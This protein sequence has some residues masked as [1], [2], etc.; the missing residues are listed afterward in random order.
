MIWSFKNSGIHFDFCISKS[1][2]LKIFGKKDF[3]KNILQKIM[4]IFLLTCYLCIMRHIWLRINEIENS[5]LFRI[6]YLKQFNS[7]VNNFS[8]NKGQIMDEFNFQELLSQPNQQQQQQQQQQ[9]GQQS[10]NSS[11]FFSSTNNN[12][13]AASNV[14]SS[15]AANV[16]ANPPTAASVIGCYYS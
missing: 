15:Q 6:N 12:S 10:N 13:S 3:F 8:S 2:D 16:G 7:I 9:N 14:L 4:S 1:Y 11:L 5:F